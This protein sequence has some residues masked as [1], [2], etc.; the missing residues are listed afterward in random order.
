MTGSIKTS[1]M[2][3][4]ENVTTLKSGLT[5]AIFLSHSLQE[6]QGDNGFNSLAGSRLR[7][8]VIC[9]GSEMDVRRSGD[10]GVD[11]PRC[12]GDCIR[13]TWAEE[14]LFIGSVK[15]NTGGASSRTEIDTA[16]EA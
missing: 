3:K 14:L 12:L 7:E 13:E 15:D 5:S 16:G 2:P 1:S 11:T 4:F 10:N 9:R 6:P 8:T